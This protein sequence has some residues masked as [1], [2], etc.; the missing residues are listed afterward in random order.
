VFCA[1]RKRGG[2]CATGCDNVIIPVATATNLQ[3]GVVCGK[4]D[5]YAPMG[6]SACPLCGND[7]AL[8]AERPRSS[9]NVPMRKP[10]SAQVAHAK[11]TPAM[12]AQ[13]GTDRRMPLSPDVAVRGS[14][15][16]PP[17]S[18]RRV[19]AR[20]TAPEVLKQPTLGGQSPSN[21]PKVEVIRRSGDAARSSS[22]Q[23]AQSADSTWG[24]DTTGKIPARPP[25]TAAKGGRSKE[26]LMD[27][28]KNYVCRSCSTP[29]PSGHKFCGRCG[30]PVPPDILSLREEYYGSLQIPGRAKLILIRAEGDAAM[31]GLSFALNAQEHIV[32]RQGHLTFPEDRFVSP[33][34][35]NLFY[36]D[37]KL[38]VRD[39]GSL[40]GVYVRVRGGVDIQPGDTFLAGEQVFRVDPTPKATDHPE[41][42]G[43]YFW[44][45]PKRPSPFRI[46]QVLMGGSAGN[47]VTARENGIAIGREGGDMNFPTDVYM[48]ATHCKVET[49]ASGAKFTLTDLNSRNGTYLRMRGERE[50][51]HGDYVFIGR[52]ILRVEL[53]S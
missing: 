14:Q 50:L 15:E 6:T 27:Q 5:G 47:C 44:S 32:G 51:N 36:R 24:H 17:L 37:G 29:I 23:S 41:P 28:A 31:E 10:S 4:C 34:H 53:T 18:E 52:K 16:T 13:G 39:E 35:A 1:A 2:G 11:T 8:D 49:D 33:R 42:D 43:T 40:N 25:I 20:P 30:A 38:V 21:S 22:S 12:P 3:I 48:S 26:E 9:A 45:S 19:A 7:L 46:T